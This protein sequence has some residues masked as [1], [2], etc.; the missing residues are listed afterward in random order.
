M[1]KLSRRVALCLAFRLK[2][3]DRDYKIS[4]PYICGG[5]RGMLNVSGRRSAPRV[6]N[7]QDVMDRMF[8][9]RIMLTCARRIHDERY[10]GLGFFPTIEDATRAVH[11]ASNKTILQ[12]LLTPAGFLLPASFDRS[13]IISGDEIRMTKD[14]VI[15]NTPIS[16]WIL[17]NA[18]YRDEPI[19]YM[20]NDL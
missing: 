18:G 2:D 1:L 17:S 11:F 10:F 4:A 9:R 13:C 14:Y 7:L 15:V 3:V 19:S 5:M 6:L 8:L 12:R 16:D 20:I